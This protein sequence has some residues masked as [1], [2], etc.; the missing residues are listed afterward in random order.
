MERFMIGQF[1]RYNDDKHKRDFRHNF[2]GVEACLLEEKSDIERLIAVA[3]DEKF[4]IGIHF[5]LDT[6]MY[7]FEIEKMITP[8]GLTE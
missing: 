1:G 7:P 5:P 3:N 6:L 2:F 8:P 4:N